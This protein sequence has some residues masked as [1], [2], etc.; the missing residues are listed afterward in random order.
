MRDI[1][2]V[3]ISSVLEEYFGEGF[4]KKWNLSKY[5]DPNSPSIFLGIFMSLYS[6]YKKLYKALEGEIK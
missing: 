6:F 2:Q 4:R 3:H 5:H 1:N